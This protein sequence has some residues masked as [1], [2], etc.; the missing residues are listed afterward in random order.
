MKRPQGFDRAAERATGPF[1][2]GRPDAEASERSTQRSAARTSGRPADPETEP[3]PV[4]APERTATVTTIL[5]EPIPPQVSDTADAAQEWAQP[6]ST[7]RELRKARRAR[8]RYERGEVK[9]FTKRARHRRAVW[10]ISL[11]SVALILLLAVAAAFSP[12]MAVT[13]IDVV[14]TSRLKPATIAHALDGQLGRPLPLIDFA[15]IKKQLAGF[16]LI[17]S[18]STETH[19]P[20]TL[21]VRIVER[22]PIGLIETSKGFEL[23]DAAGV[24]ISTSTDRPGGYPVVTQ[25]GAAGSAE[26]KAGFAASAAVLTAL[27]AS[28][29]PQVSSVTAKTTDDVTLTLQSGQKVIWGSADQSDLKA[30]DLAAL[31]K[32]APDASGYDVSSP[33]SPVTQ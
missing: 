19:P 17:R 29:L 8:R 6:A 3:I 20:G 16:A 30:A 1:A 12:L 9:R 13:K 18:Y 2:T 21:V 10:L 31:L 23:V 33:Q 25:N 14:G 28:V 26:A 27:P 32:D 15:S 7:V 22:Q 4:V 5:D 24:V 11:G